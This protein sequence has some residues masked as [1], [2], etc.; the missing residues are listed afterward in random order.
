MSMWDDKF[1]VDMFLRDR[2][3][4]V[5]YFDINGHVWHLSGYGQGWEGAT[6]GIEPS[7]MYMADTELLFTEGAR[8]D[9]AAYNGKVIQRREIDWEIQ[10]AGRTINEYHQINHKWWRGWSND[11]P[12]VIAFH[13]RT[14]GWTWAKARLVGN[15]EPKW[16]KDPSLIRAC[17]YDMTISVDNSLFVGRQEFGH[18]DNRS[19]SGN[20]KIVISNPGDVVVFPTYTMPG[21]GAYSIQD[22]PGGTMIPLPTVN[23]G[24]TMKIFTHNENLICRVYDAT[25]GIDGRTAWKGFGTKRFQNGLQPGTINE[26]KV[27][28]TGGTPTSQVMATLTPRYLKPF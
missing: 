23:S 3:T 2:R 6:L 12:G 28:V 22:G 26:I 18:W 17:D 19:S 8:Q 24:Q 10:I 1:S 14:F 15:I 25:T 13:T 20:G 16:G 5:I 21:P 4:K 9:G 11:T 7:K 27:S